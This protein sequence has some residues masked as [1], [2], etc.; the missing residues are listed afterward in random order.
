M[1]ERQLPK[2]NVA[3]SIPVSRSISSIRYAIFE[4]EKPANDVDLI[5]AFSSSTVE[6]PDDDNDDE[7]LEL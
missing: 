2:L 1:V 5:A 4:V 3:G 6:Q 7:S